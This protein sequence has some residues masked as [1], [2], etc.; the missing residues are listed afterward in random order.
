MLKKYLYDGVLHSGSD[1]VFNGL[2]DGIIWFSKFRWPKNFLRAVL[3]KMVIFSNVSF[4]WD[5]KCLR[6]VFTMDFRTQG[7][8]QFSTGF[9]TVYF[10]SRNFVGQKIP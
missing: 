5:P 8:M 10:G 9:T 7:L 4:F 2:H 1:A 3:A 6:N